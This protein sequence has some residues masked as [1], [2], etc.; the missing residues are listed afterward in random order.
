MAVRPRRIVMALFALSTCACGSGSSTA[1]QTY[2]DLSGTWSG[3][4]TVT[5]PGALAVSTVCIHQWTI[6]S[7]ANGQISGSWQ[8]LP[9]ADLA[10]VATC[11]QSGSLTGTISSLGAINLSFGAVLGVAGCTSAGGGDAASGSESVN[12]LTA[13]GQDAITCPGVVNEPR[14]LSF[15]LVKQ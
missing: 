5:H 9:D 13:S 6:G 12:R 2:P 10:V 3:N 11:Q 7:T 14:S 8:S 1:P 4:L 15:S